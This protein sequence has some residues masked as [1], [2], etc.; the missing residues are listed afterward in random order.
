MR[1]ESLKIDYKTTEMVAHVSQQIKSQQQS[2]NRP[3]VVAIDGRSGTGKSTIAQMFARILHCSVVPTDNFWSGGKDALWAAKPVEDRV[4][5]AIDWRRLRKEVI[6][7][8]KESCAVCYFPYDFTTDAGLSLAS[9]TLQPGNV[10]ILDGA[11]SARPE[12]N[13]DIDLRILVK[14][15]DLRRRAR[16]EKREGIRYMNRWHAIWDASEDYYF[17]QVLSEST[18]DAVIV[19][20]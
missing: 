14:T 3:L 10:L 20:D 6:I 13:Q 7:P 9:I 2:L 19:N 5:Q 12:L 18:F 1:Q 8:F 15:N 4:A 17:N 11:Y 16:L